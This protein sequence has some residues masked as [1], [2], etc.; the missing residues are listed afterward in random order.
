MIR[1]L[2][3]VIEQNEPVSTALQVVFPTAIEVH[4]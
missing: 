1:E 3:G 2:S 4:A